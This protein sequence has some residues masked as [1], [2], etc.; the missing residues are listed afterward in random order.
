MPGA[1]MANALFW[2]A[3]GPPKACVCCMCHLLSECLRRE[4]ACRCMRTALRI[5][6]H[7][8]GS[9][10]ERSYASRIIGHKFYHTNSQQR[11]A[12]VGS[13]RCCSA[14]RFAAC[15]PWHARQRWR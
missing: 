5:C 13:A 3:A 8:C 9:V 6:E 7:R 2:Q 11:A 14:H 12:Y 15:T 4:P 1:V 10:W